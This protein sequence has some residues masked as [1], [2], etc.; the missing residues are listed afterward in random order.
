M[1]RAP[2]TGYFEMLYRLPRRY[3]EMD[4][5]YG[6]EANIVNTR[7]S[8]DLPDRLAATMDYVIAGLHRR[9]SYQGD[10]ISAHTEAVVSVIRTRKA[11]I[12]AH[13]VSSSF[14]TDPEQIVCAAAE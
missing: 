10:S 14:L 11:D 8:I 2:H 12:V 6:C 9:T 7:G 3:G 13:P 1:E 4:V 5:L